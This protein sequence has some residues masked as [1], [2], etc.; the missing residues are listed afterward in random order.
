LLGFRSRAWAGP[1]LAGARRRDRKATCNDRHASTFIEFSMK[2]VCACACV[3]VCARLFCLL[4]SQNISSSKLA[5]LRKLAKFDEVKGRLFP[6]VSWALSLKFA[7]GYLG[8]DLHTLQGVLACPAT[9]RDDTNHIHHW[10]SLIGI[11][12]YLSTTRP[13][14]VKWC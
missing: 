5:V 13:L 7:L 2:P 1:T 8:N 9:F 11:L 4:S 6:A 12:R 10:N 3:R 14:F